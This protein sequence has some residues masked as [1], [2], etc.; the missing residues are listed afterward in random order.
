[1]VVGPMDQ[2]SFGKN[3]RLSSQFGLEHRSEFLH[4]SH[5]K[6]A[7]PSSAKGH[8]KRQYRLLPLPEYRNDRQSACYLHAPYRL[9]AMVAS[10]GFHI[11]AAVIAE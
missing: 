6:L 7:Q 9:V 3:S 5:P 1:M 11:L 10:R 4:R 8:Q 2:G